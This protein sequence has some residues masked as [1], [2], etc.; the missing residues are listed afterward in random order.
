MEEKLKKKEVK[1]TNAPSPFCYRP[2]LAIEKSTRVNKAN[3][4][5]TIGK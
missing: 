2:E 1:K 3:T 4:F 5:H